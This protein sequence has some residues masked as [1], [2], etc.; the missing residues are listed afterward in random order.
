MQSI[1]TK[2]IVLPLS[3]IQHPAVFRLIVN[4]LHMDCLFQYGKGAVKFYGGNSG[5][6]LL[7]LGM[8]FYLMD[9]P[10]FPVLVLY[11]QHQGRNFSRFGKPALAGDFLLRPPDNSG[12]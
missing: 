6:Q 8:H 10:D 12:I 9:Y 1:L 2:Y 4:Q 3:K 7:F 11:L 5:I